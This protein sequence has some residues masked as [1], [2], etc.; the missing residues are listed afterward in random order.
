[1]NSTVKKS[2]RNRAR[3]VAALGAAVALTLGSV[4]PALAAPGPN[5]STSAGTWIKNKAFD[6]HNCPIGTTVQLQ[7][8]TRGEVRVF[9]STNGTQGSLIGNYNTGSASGWRYINTGYSRYYAG[10]YG[11]TT[12]GGDIRNWGFRCVN[13]S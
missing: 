8:E 10:A 6:W 9:G 3:I 13:F 1:M 7:F 5:A 2:G 4:A 11:I 12:Y